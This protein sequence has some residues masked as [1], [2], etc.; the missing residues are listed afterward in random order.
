MEP[1]PVSIHRFTATR[2]NICGENCT[3]RAAGLPTIALLRADLAA[4]TPLG[5]I[6][7]NKEGTGLDS[8]SPLLFCLIQAITI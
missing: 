2:Q 1:R 7:G 8:Q 6:G 3:S 4:A 5:M